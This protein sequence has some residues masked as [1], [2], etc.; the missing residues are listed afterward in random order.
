MHD[1]RLAQQF[2]EVLAGDKDAHV[3]W[4]TF[5]DDRARDDRRL[6][7]TAEQSIATAWSKL[8]GLNK[9]GAGVYATINATDGKGHKAENV[10]GIRFVFADF[11]KGD[12]D[13]AKLAKM[14][15]PTMVVMSRNGPHYYWAL[16]EPMSS[17]AAFQACTTDYCGRLRFRSVVMNPNR[18]MRVPGRSTK[19]MRHSMLGLARL[20]RAGRI[21]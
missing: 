4:Q 11:D 8:I 17:V 3:S 21:H 6:V 12:P 18:V 16:S 5:D 13:P 10:T 1:I 7:W 20:I 19:R 15:P 9:K 14:P 2:V